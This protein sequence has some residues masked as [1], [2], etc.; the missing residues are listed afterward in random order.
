MNA[1]TG[2][3][4]LR[5]RLTQPVHTFSEDWW[6]AC[7]YFQLIYRKRAHI[8]SRLTQ[9]VH[10][11]SADLCKL[12]THLQEIYAKR[13][14]IFSRL[15]QSVHSFSADYSK[16]AH[17]AFISIYSKHTVINIYVNHN[18]PQTQKRVDN[19]KSPWAQPILLLGTV[20]RYLSLITED[21]TNQQTRLY[22]KKDLKMLNTF[23]CYRQDTFQVWHRSSRW[24]DLNKRRR[25]TCKQS[26]GKL[27]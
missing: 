15:T 17:P 2:V 9:S 12:C 3:C 23:R 26:W 11:F 19:K 8:Y 10:T 21:I 20:V 7:T 14:H 5:S 25:H 18:T 24:K 4:T 6:K 27:M 22:W 13:A 16:C 1:Q